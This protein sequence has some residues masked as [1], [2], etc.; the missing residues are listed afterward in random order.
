MS[1]TKLPVGELFSPQG[2]TVICTG[3]TG[4]IGQEMCITLAEAGAEIVS[5]QVPDD[6]YAPV[7][8]HR[9]ENLGRS[10]RAFECDLRDASAMRQTFQAIWDA[11]IVPDVTGTSVVVDGGMLGA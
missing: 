4:G 11:G 9:L 2:K 5:I 6:P 1:A 8:S 3:A 10:L 7:L